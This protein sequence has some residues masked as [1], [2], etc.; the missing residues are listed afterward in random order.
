MKIGDLCWVAHAYDVEYRATPMEIVDITSEND[1]TLYW[2][3]V[4]AHN[5]AGRR[6]EKVF[7]SFDKV[8]GDKFDCEDYIW[9]YYYDRLCRDCKYEKTAG[10]IL[11]CSACVHNQH[12]KALD[13]TKW[14][15]GKCELCG[16][17]V[18][19]AE[20]RHIG[21]PI[22]KHFSPIRGY[23][24]YKKY[25]DLLKNCDFN[26]DCP[27]HKESAHKT[28]SFDKYMNEYVKVPVDLKYNGR[29]VSYVF[30]KRSEWCDQNFIDDGNIKCWGVKYE[31]EYTKSGKI[32]KG[33]VN[34]VEAF[35]KQ[36]I[37]LFGE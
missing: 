16:I 34:N 1:K 29:Q 26:P 36:M 28:C 18:W 11:N 13:V 17:T 3:Y 2:G 21:M 5:F 20:K 33:T 31:P 35:D 30:V 23:W 22:C 27:H 32:K 14:D 6:T 25:V 7:R 4:T 10:T 8:F 15:Y 37:L 9:N 12:I 19:S 24:S